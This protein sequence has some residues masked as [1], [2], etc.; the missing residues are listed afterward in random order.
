MNIERSEFINGTSKMCNL[1][2]PSVFFP[3]FSPLMSNAKPGATTNY[4]FVSLRCDQ[5]EE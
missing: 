3:L 2:K 5:T 1:S 4:N